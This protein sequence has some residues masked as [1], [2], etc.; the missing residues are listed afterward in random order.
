MNISNILILYPGNSGQVSG[1]A[2]PPGH[3]YAQATG[4]PA[5][6]NSRS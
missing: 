1:A 6:V 5:K 2:S 3:S 4:K